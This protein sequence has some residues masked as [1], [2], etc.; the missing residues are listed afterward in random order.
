MG[1]LIHELIF[2]AAARAPAAPALRHHAAT[3]SY[4]ALARDVARAGA[5]LCALGARHNDRVAV[6]L[7][8]GIEA[9]VALFGAAAAGSAVVPLDPRGDAARAAAHLADAGPRVLVTTG[10]RLAQL[11]RA[12][13]RWPQLRVI[14]LCGPGGA[15][16]DGALLVDWDQ[17][18]AVQAEPAAP[19]SVE[20]DLA[21][22]VYGAGGSGVALSHRNLV[23]AADS[24]V[25]CLG[26]GARDRLLAAL[27]PSLDHG[28]NQLTAAFAAGALAVLADPATPEELVRAVERDE[29]T[30]LAGNPSLWAELAG[31]DWSRARATLRHATSIGKP[32]AAPLVDTL[33]RALPNTRLHLM[34]GFTEAFRATCLAPEQLARHPDAIG[35]PAPGAGI[36]VLRPDGGRCA[37]GEPGELVQRGPMVA[38]G[39]W[40]D[41]QRT[42]ARFR[43]LAPRPGLSLPE[44]AVWSGDTVRFDAHGNLYVVR[45][46]DDSIRIGGVSVDPAEV[47]RAVYDT[48]LVHEAAAV[49]VAH[50][51]RGQVIAVLARPRAGCRLDSGI[52]FDACQARLPTHMLPAMVDVRRSPLPRA[53]DGLIDRELLAGELAPLFA[54]ARP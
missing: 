42:A 28:L 39:Y 46:F 47:E 29:I 45:R 16:T 9:V 37:A 10:A 5:S 19:A 35:K 36:L 3:L 2:D 54:E 34:Y 20:T 14:I 32:L 27:P 41:P 51:V 4:A 49:G 13:L 22:L 15:V 6:W 18:M 21:A 17:F 48:G 8:A 23:A 43:A 44:T 30:I 24:T 33:R 11:G 53:A 40:N 25:R 26:I 1:Q 12:R 38:L 52:V 50:P 7:P 31:C